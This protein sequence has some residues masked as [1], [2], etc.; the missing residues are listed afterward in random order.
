MWTG[1]RCVIVTMLGVAVVGFAPAGAAADDS[2]DA[3]D[4]GLQP[5]TATFQGYQ[6]TDRRELVAAGGGK[7]EAGLIYLRVNQETT[8]A[9]YSLDPT[10][11]P[12]VSGNWASVQ[13]DTPGVRG[14]ASAKWLISNASGVPGQLPDNNAEAAAIQL[15]IWNRAVGY[16]LVAA[17]VP[18]SEIAARARA[19]AAAAPESGSPATTVSRLEISMYQQI[20]DN[21]HVTITITLA[22]QDETTFDH[23]QKLD[24]RIGGRWGVVHTHHSTDI[25]HYGPGKSL[26]LQVG[27]SVGDNNTAVMRLKRTD[28][29]TQL[30]VFWGVTLDPELVLLGSPGQPAMMTA[31]PTALRIRRVYLTNPDQFPN[32]QDLL[33]RSVLSVLRHAH[34]WLGWVLLIVG[35]YVVSQL[36]GW[37]NAL[38]RMGWKRVIRRRAS[39]EPAPPAQ[40][41]TGSS[42][43]PSEQP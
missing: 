7:V 12:T 5:V 39:T 40:P 33:S 9:T 8:I 23:E 31:T 21:E 32:G 29:A 6:S 3:T 41:P 34:G 10:Q 19:L 16:P 26:P 30:E 13:G 37:I 24:V 28:D 11:L 38:A 20:V 22:T 43:G 15:A 36:A 42:S 1:L 2:G 14:V 17:N 18:D 4:A 27:D 25:N 35:L